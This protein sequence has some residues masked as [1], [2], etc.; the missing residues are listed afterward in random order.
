MSEDPARPCLLLALLALGAAVGSSGGGVAGRGGERRRRNG[1]REL[2]RA[3]CAAKTAASV[4]AS[5]RQ[6]QLLPALA[7]VSG[8]FELLSQR[9]IAV[10]RPRERRAAGASSPR[11]PPSAP[12][13]RRRESRAWMRPGAEARPVRRTAPT[14]RRGMRCRRAVSGRSPRRR[15]MGA[16]RRAAQQRRSRHVGSRRW[17]SPAPQPGR[18]GRP[19]G[20]RRKRAASSPTLGCRSSENPELEAAPARGAQPRAILEARIVE[21][22]SSNG[23]EIGGQRRHRIETGEAS[24]RGRGSR[25]GRR[26]APARLRGDRDVLRG[27]SR[28]RPG[29]ELLEADGALAAAL[30]DAARRRLELGEADASSSSTRPRSARR[31]RPPAGCCEQRCGERG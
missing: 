19:A 20:A 18:R 24:S 5:R 12:R 10:A 21:W 26:V 14:K 8:S 15:R 7:K 22:G 4:F 2:R 9:K 23:F 1:S 28:R 3:K 27:R 16:V 6:V 25:G 31:G 29:V 30:E 11:V 13:L 17:S